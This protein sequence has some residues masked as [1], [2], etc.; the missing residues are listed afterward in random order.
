M[1][2]LLCSNDYR[3]YIPNITVDATGAGGQALSP[4]YQASGQCP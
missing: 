1:L 3:V 4:S 2:E